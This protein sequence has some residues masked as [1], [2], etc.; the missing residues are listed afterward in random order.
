MQRIV[1]MGSVLQA[2]SLRE[3]IEEVS[4]VR[5][6]FLDI[7]DAP[8]LESRRSVKDSED[9]EAP[10]ALSMHPLQRA[11]RK[12]ISKLSARTKALIRQF[13]ADELKLTDANSLNAYDHVI[14]GSDEV[15][16]H[17]KGI[18]LQLH[19]NVR[20]AKN[21]FTYAASC[22]SAV[23][24][25][26]REEDLPKVRQALSRLCAVSVR[27]EKTASYVRSLCCAETEHHLDPVL[28]GSLH[29][30]APKKVPFQKYLLVYAY[31]QR[32][33]TAEEIDAIR[34][35]AKA[36]GLK[37]IA[38]GG[39]QFWCDFYIPV[40]PMRA[41]DYF[42]FA[43]Y[44]VT[45]TFHGAIF[46]IINRRRFAV[47]M[48]KT[49]QGKLTSLLADLGLEDRR[50]GQMSKL[51]G[52][53]ESEIRYDEV[54]AILDR[55]RIRARAYLKKQL[56]GRTMNLAERKD[57]SACGACYAVCPKKAIEMVEEKDGFKYPRINETLCVRCGLCEKICLQRETE[58]R[59]FPLQAFA[60]VGKNEKMVRRSASGGVFA[61][62]AS[63]I[64][65]ENGAAAGAVMEKDG[66]SFRVYHQLTGNI[67]D[68]AA[69]QGSKYMQSDAWECF[70]EV[71]EAVR[72]G[73]R[74]LFSG[75]PCQVSAVKRLTGDPDNLI[76]MD[77]ICHGVPSA[78][79][80]NEYAAILGKRFGGQLARIRFRDKESGKNFYPAMDIERQGRSRTYC[81]SSSLMS[82]YKLF[83]SGSIYRENCYSCPYASLRRVSDLT[84]GDYWGVEEAH[85]G[86]FAQGRM[87]KRSDWSCIL[88]NTGKGRRL[89][90]SCADEMTL[91]ES[92]P[93]WAA[94]K[95]A[96]LN[97]PSIKPDN[98]DA[99]M[100]RYAEGGYGA[101]ERAF[102]KTHGGALRYSWR[103]IKNIK[104]NRR[105][106]SK[107]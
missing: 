50:V 63:Q 24:E 88:V 14:I 41:L 83:L 36:R 16:N 101:V 28:M 19:G 37:T 58:Q 11:K 13:M 35:F 106:G 57:C 74:V 90:E 22:G 80:F 85:A 82:F 67:A 27:D 65:A 97:A 107:K 62:V 96:Q 34:A 60:A 39:S 7:E 21:V 64:V 72:S 103:L 92:R 20:Q 52:V 71:A 31:G 102:V 44:V 76:T 100:Q 68:L 70:A 3:M 45:D 18:R 84:I 98:R 25:D 89:I 53:L 77:L 26:I 17:T 38:I 59:N 69:M 48:R 30:R 95:N 32:I 10:A 12:V 66:G 93:E 105:K 46:S 55:E 2:Y 79:M 78:R 104:E 73:Q 49:N 51:E 91:I 56:G 15:F 94:K 86:D 5:A 6:D 40:S 54:D 43:D 9:Y 4:G 33:R 29:K 8:A 99:V 42:H 23:P 87:E 1:N 75:T 47:I 61:A 81:F